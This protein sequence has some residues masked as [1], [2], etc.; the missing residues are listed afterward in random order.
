M[1]SKKQSAEIY[2]GTKFET[3]F[4]KKVIP[5]DERIAELQQWCH[6]FAQTNLAPV[7]DSGS[8]GNLSFRV[9]EGEESFIIT[10]TATNL[11]EADVNIS[12]VLVRSCDVVSNTVFAT[13]IQE[14]S[15][16]AM[17]H[18]EI[19][20][21][22]P[23]INA[24]FH[25]HSDVILNRAMQLSIPVTER[26]EPYGSIALV[27][28]A[29]SLCENDFFILKKHGFVSLGSNMNK[30]GKLTLDVLGKCRN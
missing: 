28:A 21:K 1:K 4:Q 30:A 14:P 12:F 10:A 3:V 8:A 17:L 24:I 29:K 7:L 19:Y 18:A 11:N 2:I 6:V 22:R 9:R 26:E 23:D 20:K 16:E 13:G 15:S 25:G 5:Q 27:D